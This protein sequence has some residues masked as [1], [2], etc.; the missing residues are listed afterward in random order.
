MIETLSKIVLIANANASNLPSN[1]IRNPSKF[2]RSFQCESMQALSRLRCKPHSEIHAILSHICTASKNVTNR[3][4]FHLTKKQ[5]T[6][7][8]QT[9]IQSHSRRR[10]VPIDDRR[11]TAATASTCQYR[12]RCML[13]AVDSL[14]EQLSKTSKKNGVI[15][16]KSTNFSRPRVLINNCMYRRIDG[17][18]QNKQTITAT[19]SFTPFS[20]AVRQPTAMCVQFLPFSRL[21]CVVVIAI[22]ERIF[23]R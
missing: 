20:A 4:P 18:K 10:R 8:P 12:R 1:F 2:P 9:N 17:I 14:V 16:N 3:A 13:A 6:A 7:L 5:Q 19:E 22:C 11:C 15:S 21:A 23:P